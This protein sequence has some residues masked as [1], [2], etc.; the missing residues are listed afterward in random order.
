MWELSWI[1]T[2][3]EIGRDFSAQFYCLSSLVKAKA[4]KVRCSGEEA[5]HRVVSIMTV[6]LKMNCLTDATH[7]ASLQKDLPVQFPTGDRSLS[8]RLFR[9]FRAPTDKERFWTCTAPE[10]ELSIRLDV[11]DFPYAFN[12]SYNYRQEPPFACR[13]AHMD[14]IPVSLA[15]RASFKWWID[16]KPVRHWPS[17][18]ILCIGF[19]GASSI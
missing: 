14:S 12:D 16:T 13:R 18:F 5:L 6:K 4:V 17:T 11:S 15:F 3:V 9:V 2:E 19:E 7:W 1:G 10:G 8:L